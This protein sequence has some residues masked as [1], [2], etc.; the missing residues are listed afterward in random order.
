MMSKYR[1]QPPDESDHQR[2]LRKSEKKYIQRYTISDHLTNGVSTKEPEKCRRSIRNTIR[3][4]YVTDE[5]KENSKK[6]FT[7]S[8]TMSQMSKNP[9]SFNLN[10]K[11]SKK[12]NTGSEKM[13]LHI[14]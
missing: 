6:N 12:W 8:K 5:I 14:K 4:V 1:L 2:F 13:I 3:M 10:S 7:N 9:K 11:K